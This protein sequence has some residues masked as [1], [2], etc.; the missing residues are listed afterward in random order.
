MNT[1]LEVPS[2]PADPALY[3]EMG[4]RR[5]RCLACAHRCT[6]GP[7][8]TGICR[9][10]SNRE[11]EM[12]VPGNYVAGLQID[13]VEKKPFYHVIPGRAALSFG[14][15]GCNFQCS[16]CQN[17]ISSQT[18]RDPAAV[19]TIRPISAETIVTIARQENTPIII[20]TYNEPL[21]SV[22]W[23][24]GIFERA[25]AH[26]LKCGF[27]SNGFAT[28]ESLTF[29]K[30][31][32]DLYKVDLKSFDDRQYRM[33]GGRL[34]DVLDALEIIVALGYWLEVVT[35]IVSGFND[36]EKSLRGIAGFLCSLSP[37]IP[38]H[39]TAFHPAYKMKDRPATEQNALTRAYAAGK[40]AGLRFVYQ[41][42]T[43][44]ASPE[45]E[46]TYCPACRACLIKRYGF[47]VTH[48]RML[49]GCC[50][51]CNTPIPGVWK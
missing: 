8:G 33:L 39:V 13:P 3:E 5:I 15:L 14:M 50:P 9:V 6:M 7:G 47:T 21:I 29:M 17:W 23:S 43:P 16:F 48:N 19:S 49:Y 25:R 41:G 28:S 46:H 26:G 31:F 11:G 24:A 30:P 18:H 2:M 42:N 10:R 20:S 40:S 1:M 34:A 51:D 22:E 4:G 45:H 35:L 38:W 36:D 44:G 12:R 27:V 37:D 32:M